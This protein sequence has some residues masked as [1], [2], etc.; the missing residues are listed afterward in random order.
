MTVKVRTVSLFRSREVV[1]VGRGQRE[2]VRGW[3]EKYKS[4][5]E[6]WI[7]RVFF[8]MEVW[9]IYNIILVSVFNIV[10]QNFRDYTPFKVI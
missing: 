5:P 2:G 3:M 8:L 1:E 4:W 10:I 6:W 9:S 7:T